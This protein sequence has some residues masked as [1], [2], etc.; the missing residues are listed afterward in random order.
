MEP[1]IY[2]NYETIQK[3]NSLSF[4]TINKKLKLSQLKLLSYAI[5]KL[6]LSGDTATFRMQEF[7][8]FLGVQKY[9][10]RQY[11][12]DS[13]AIMEIL[14]A[15]QDEEFEEDDNGNKG[16]QEKLNL[17]RKMKYSNGE[18]TCTFESQLLPKLQELSVK[19]MTLDLSIMKK[20][21]S[22]FSWYLYEHLKANYGNKYHRV[23]KL[24]MTVDEVKKMF[25]IDN[26]V[27]YATNFN[28]VKSKALN[29]AVD[30]INKLT[31]ISV[32]TR[33]IKDGVKIAA[34]EFEWTIDEVEYGVTPKQVEYFEERMTE[35]LSREN[36]TENPKYITFVRMYET[37]DYKNMTKEQMDIAIRKTDSII[38]EIDAEL[39]MQLADT[40]DLDDERIIESIK[41]RTLETLLANGASQSAAEFLQF[42]YFDSSFEIAKINMKH[43][44]SV[45]SIAEYVAKTI[46]SQA[47]LKLGN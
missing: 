10:K 3:A 37:L 30:E 23:K 18:I 5:L 12:V 9:L 11:D 20:F 42:Q 25:H 47:G 39:R 31:E 24:E 46:L 40:I 13:S 27:S 2:N 21:K 26:K 33:E 44:D 38:A 29:K 45:D 4:S 34:I 19:Y 1:I 7:S 17:I 32:K 41:E 35:L 28:L 22:E 6:P 14:F 43:K 15:V 36:F 16:N 8:E